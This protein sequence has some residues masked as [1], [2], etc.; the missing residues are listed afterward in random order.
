MF[1]QFLVIREDMGY[2]TFCRK[3]AVGTDF[4]QAGSAR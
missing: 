4:L 3:I 1:A 2:Y